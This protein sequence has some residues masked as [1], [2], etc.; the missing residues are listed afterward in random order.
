MCLKRRSENKRLTCI[1]MV[2]VV[3]L[4]MA[5]STFAA[6]QKVF[7]WRAVSHQM[8]GTARHEMTV[9]PFC[10]MVEEASNGRLIIE[11]FG[12]GILFPVFDTFEAIQSGTIE[13]AMVWNGYWAGNDPV[14]ALAGNIPGDPITDFGEHYYR[15][16]KTG[17][18]LEKTYAKYGIKDL[19][20]FDFGP[21]EILM[22]NKPVKSLN[23]FK[24]LNIRSAGISGIFYTR[25]GASAVSLSA[26]EIYTA[27]QTGTVDGAEYNDWQ[28]NKEMGLQEVTKFVIEPMLHQGAIDDK[29]L[30]VNPD[31]W[32]ELPDD[33]KKVVLNA[34][35]A[36]RYLSAVAYHVGNKKA[37][38]EWMN[39]GVKVVTLPEE[40]AEKG[41]AIA[42]E[43]LLEY[44]QKSAECADY[45]N[46]YAQALKELGY[47]EMAAKLLK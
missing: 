29:Q 11:P 34:R 2:I 39:S 22:S 41:R 9:V 44:K 31:A 18:V 1:V 26:P 36:A 33:L 15:V 45:I 24:G 6:E 5:T 35:D 10:K 12:A 13:M 43:L 19:G 30:I 8:A 27:L 25:L 28:V 16:A 40:E 3:L 4:V 20:G 7:R 23:E 38:I 32:D 17:P 47:E 42:A 14:F 46:A 37:R 21:A